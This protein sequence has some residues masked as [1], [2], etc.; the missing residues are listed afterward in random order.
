MIMSGFSGVV[1]M[2]VT[3]PV[4]PLM[5]PFNVKRSDAIFRRRVRRR[6]PT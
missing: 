4:W 2:E 3:H 5:I 1:A 6:V